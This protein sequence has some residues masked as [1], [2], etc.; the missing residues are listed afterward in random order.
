MKLS[1][2]LSLLS[3]MFVL[4]IATNVLAAVPN[5]N[6]NQNSERFHRMPP[7]TPVRIPAAYEFPADCQ[8]SHALCL[9][10]P[11]RIIGE[12]I[13]RPGWSMP[14]PNAPWNQGVKK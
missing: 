4:L 7:Q 14:A 5:S 6:A 13:Q 11:T 3:C 9:Q 2:K 8:F 1:I 12:P 10:Q